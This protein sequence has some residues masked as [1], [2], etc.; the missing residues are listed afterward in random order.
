[1]K[2]LLRMILAAESKE[3]PKAK[4]DE[5]INWFGLK[6]KSASGRVWKKAFEDTLGEQKMYATG[7][8]SLVKGVV[9]WVAWTVF[10]TKAA[11]ESKDSAA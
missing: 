2:S 4:E 10:A 6:L 5:T 9:R 3:K 7:A 1:M 8:S 11:S